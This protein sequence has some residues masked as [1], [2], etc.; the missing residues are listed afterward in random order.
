MSKNSHWQFS[1]AGPDITSYCI[2]ILSE[3]DK[4]RRKTPDRVIPRG[5]M[6][7]NFWPFLRKRQT[8][9]TYTPTSRTLSNPLLVKGLKI[10]VVLQWPKVSVKN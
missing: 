9:Y 4:V 1:H 8:K 6:K 7:P 5:F 2:S 10:R 3:P